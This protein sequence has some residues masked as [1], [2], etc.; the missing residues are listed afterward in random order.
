MSWEKNDYFFVVAIILAINRGS[1]VIVRTN[2]NEEEIKQL[3]E[4][5]GR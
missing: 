3:S 5:Y 4:K 1:N 2:E